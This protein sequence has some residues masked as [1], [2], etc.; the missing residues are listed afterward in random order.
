MSRRLIGQTSRRC[1]RRTPYST[2]L[3]LM[4]GLALVAGGCARSEAAG[5][6]PPPARQ[7]ASQTC[8]AAGAIVRQ[9]LAMRTDRLSPADNNKAVGLAAALRRL[10]D[11]AEDDAVQERLDY[12]ADAVQTFAAAVQ[13]GDPSAV[14]GARDVV[15]GFARTCP[16]A[17]ATL[18]E[19]PGQW[20]ADSAN[21]VVR[22]GPNGPLGGSAL[23]VSSRQA[24]SCGLQDSSRA[25]TSTLPG[26][27][28]L[29]VWV[30]SSSGKQT[31]TAH[32]DELSGATRVSQ[33]S[34]TIT[35]DTSWKRLTV[36]LRP[37][38]P[39]HSALAVGVSAM[40]PAAGV[41]FLAGNVSV[42]WG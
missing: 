36:S 33:A 6:K 2:V 22:G 38:S 41:C 3:V 40:S 31:V 10:S 13:A 11:A 9:V 15:T 18:V 34:S 28:R 4:L 30:R 39:K 16:V 37:R 19:G 12:T 23:E 5:Q 1:R 14:L 35:A 42:I 27:Y 8:V 29:R 17:D 25:V 7:D 26:V 20:V 32:I 21:S 24:G